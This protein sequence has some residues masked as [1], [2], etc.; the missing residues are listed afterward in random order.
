MSDK[1]FF[2]GKFGDPGDMDDVLVQPLHFGPFKCPLPRRICFL[3]KQ[4]V[5]SSGIWVGDFFSQLFLDKG[6]NL[7]GVLMNG[8]AGSP[9]GGHE[10]AIV[11]ILIKPTSLSRRHR[12]QEGYK[13][14]PI[15]LHRRWAGPFNGFRKWGA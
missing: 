11:E 10:T 14:S 7:L 5:F 6:I 9:F 4:P 8:L 3:E 13:T 2:L 15:I 1:E 12:Q